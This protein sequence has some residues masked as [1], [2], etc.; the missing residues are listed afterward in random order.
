MTFSELIEDVLNTQIRDDQE[1]IEGLMMP[2]NMF[3]TWVF[4]WWK[5]EGSQCKRC[6]KF[7]IK[8]SYEFFFIVF[9]MFSSKLFRIV[10]SVCV[11]RVCIFRIEIITGNEPKASIS[12]L[13]NYIVLGTALMLITDEL[14]LFIKLY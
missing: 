7:E 12:R 1:E 8:I 11:D 9:K 14:A 6:L 4:I 5:S 2:S 13:E 3:L 10:F